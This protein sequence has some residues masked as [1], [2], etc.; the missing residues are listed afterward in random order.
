MPWQEKYQLQNEVMDQT[1]Q[2]FIELLSQLNQAK[3]SEFVDRFYSLQAHIQQH[4]DQ[5]LQWMKKSGFSATVEHHDDHQRILGELNQMSLR[6]RP[7]TLP[8][9]KAW[10]SDRLPRWFEL[11]VSTMDSALASSL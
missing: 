9:V 3:G 1:H 8:L 11:H 6:L 5:E 4:F 2:E 10:A 7:G